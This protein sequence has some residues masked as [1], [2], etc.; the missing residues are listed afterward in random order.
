VDGS[1]EVDESGKKSGRGAYVCRSR[2]CW[3]RAL[4]SKVLEYALKTPI[5]V[6]QRATL[7]AYADGLDEESKPQATDKTAQRLEQ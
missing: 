1:V 7:Q 4:K 2:A 6:E 5:S 3:D